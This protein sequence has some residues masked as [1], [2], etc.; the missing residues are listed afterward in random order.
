MAMNLPEL[1]YF[2]H[3]WAP[4]FVRNTLISAASAACHALILCE[5]HQ[6]LMLHTAVPMKS[7]RESCSSSCGANNLRLELRVLTF[8]LWW[9][10]S[11]F[12]YG[13]RAVADIIR[14]Q[15]CD[16][17][18]FQEIDVETLQGIRSELVERGFACT[19]DTDSKILTRL[20][21]LRPLIA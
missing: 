9:S 5:M 4:T 21:I 16:V 12:P 2:E 20:P 8:N 18:C 7:V 6:I 17:V 10:L 15:R 3:D 1:R 14:A 11:K 19:C 13:K